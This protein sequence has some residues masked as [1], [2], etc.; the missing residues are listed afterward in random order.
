MTVTYN[1]VRF[2]PSYDYPVYNTAETGQ[3]MVLTK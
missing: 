1:R 2:L 3:C